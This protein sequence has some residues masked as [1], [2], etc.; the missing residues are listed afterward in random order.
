M[1]VE[2]TVVDVKP[3][4]V[5]AVV[6]DNIGRG[7][8]MYCLCGHATLCSP[9]LVDEAQEMEDHWAAEHGWVAP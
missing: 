4:G 3:T 1:A 6:W 5:E 7:W 2:Q 9:S 8:R